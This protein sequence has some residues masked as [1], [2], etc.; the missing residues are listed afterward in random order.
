MGGAV[1]AA[2]TLFESA[3]HNQTKAMIHEEG[4]FLLAK[5]SWAFSGVQSVVLPSVGSPGSLLQVT[6]WNASIGTVSIA[7]SGTDMTITRGSP[8]VTETLNNSNVSVS[9]LLFTHTYNGGGNPESMDIQFTV[10][11]RDAR[12]T[13]ISEDFFSTIYARK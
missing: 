13:I 8:A 11:A 6:K 12:G 7:L 9:A 3:S 1:V 5:I 10:S 2:Y 4:S